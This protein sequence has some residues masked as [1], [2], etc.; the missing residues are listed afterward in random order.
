M[1]RRR[2][3][4]EVLTEVPME[5]LPELPREVPLINARRAKAITKS[6]SCLSGIFRITRK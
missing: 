5:L 1:A 2:F 3:F 4:F 6:E